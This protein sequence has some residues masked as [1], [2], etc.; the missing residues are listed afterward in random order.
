MKEDE[1]KMKHI[2]ENLARGVTCDYAPMQSGVLMLTSK[3]KQESEAVDIKTFFALR[4]QKL[5]SLKNTL[6][7]WHPIFRP[8]MLA[9]IYVYEITDLGRKYLTR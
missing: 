9:P 3:E 1:Q 2:L 6:R 8:S 7:N 4:D 5:I